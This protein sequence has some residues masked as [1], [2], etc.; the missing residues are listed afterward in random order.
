[1][2]PSAS[3]STRMNGTKAFGIRRAVKPQSLSAMAKLSR[4][5]RVPAMP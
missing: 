1:M 4:Q 2:V 3:T 5:L